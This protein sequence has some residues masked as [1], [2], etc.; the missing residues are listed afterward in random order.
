MRLRVA[1]SVIEETSLVDGTVEPYRN[2]QARNARASDAVLRLATRTPLAAQDGLMTD[3]PPSRDDRP[4]ADAEE[5]LEAT[6][7][8]WRSTLDEEAKE[9]ADEVARGADNAAEQPDYGIE[10]N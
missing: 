2:W 10:G 8:G 3:S 5:E 7:D 9:S 1:V 6:A 4:D